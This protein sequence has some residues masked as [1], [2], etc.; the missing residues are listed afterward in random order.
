[1]GSFPGFS[2][3]EEPLRNPAPPVPLE[4][5]SQNLSKTVSSGGSHA[6][7]S[8]TSTLPDE[9]GFSLHGLFCFG[10]LAT[11]VRPL[12]RGKVSLY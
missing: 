7:S 10:G 2:S 4:L 6:C 1:M 9:V 12:I 8:L 3:P 11:P 5:L